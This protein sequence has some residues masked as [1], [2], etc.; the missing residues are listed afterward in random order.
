MAPYEIRADSAPYPWSMGAWLALKQSK[1]E[2]E[3]LAPTPAKQSPEILYE[4][5]P[6]VG[7]LEIFE[8][9]AA[10]NPEARTWPTERTTV[11]HARELVAGLTAQWWML[12]DVLAEGPQVLT[13]E[14]QG[15]L[16][17]LFRQWADTH[18][19]FGRDGAYL[20]GRWNMVDAAFT[21]LVGA[22]LNSNVKLD[23]ATS[24]YCEAVW[25]FPTVRL[26]LAAHPV[27]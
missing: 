19:L 18:K 6:I 17:P 23:R 10:R 3:E 12:R 8:H 21:P 26:W 14:T 11:L 24:R 1:Q 20:F 4:G 13:G 7:F 15:R 16:E 2:F 25:A 22:L 5:R 27:R 9:L